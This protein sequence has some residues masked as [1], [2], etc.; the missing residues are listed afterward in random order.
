M[1]VTEDEMDGFAVSKKTSLW[2]QHASM[3]NLHNLT[4]KTTI[5]T[6]SASKPSSSKGGFFKKI[7]AK[8]RLKTNN[9]TSNNN[10]NDSNEENFGKMSRDGNGKNSS[11]RW[12]KEDL[13][14]PGMTSE[15]PTAAL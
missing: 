5:T 10:K 6:A 2:P 9:N 13:A 7:K 3:K 1:S 12:D 14:L 4:K 15:P 8:F 11:R